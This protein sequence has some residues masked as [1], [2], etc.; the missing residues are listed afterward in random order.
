MHIMMFLS[1]KR[2]WPFAFLLSVS[3][4]GACKKDKTAA[5]VVF[6]VPV[7]QVTQR[8]VPIYREFVGQVL[9][10]SDIEL[11]A[12]VDGWITGLHFTEGGAVKK[13]QLLYSIDPL[14]YRTKVDQARGQVASAEATLANADANLKRIRPLAAINAVSKRDLDAAVADYDVS[15]AQVEAAKANLENQRI[16]LSYT[17]VTSPIDGVIG[18]SKIQVGNYVSSLGAN[19]LLNTVSKINS[20]R[21]RFPVGEQ[22]LLRFQKISR[23]HPDEK[24]LGLEAHLILADGSVFP[25][26]GIVNTVD[27]QVDASTGTLTLQATFPNP[28]QT[29]RPGQFARV[30]LIFENRKNAIVIP[31]RAVTEMQGIFQVMTLTPDNKLQAK[32]VQAGQQIGDEW[33]IDSGLTATDKVALLGNQFI[34]ANTVVKPVAANW[35][36]VDSVSTKK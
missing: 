11:R 21:V 7:L 13:G 29:V 20:L 25:G 6:E 26:K 3:I 36:S 2:A 4:F 1:T 10:E 27:R 30:R 17:Q 34:Q 23:E 5:A 22:D 12:R 9:G 28:D 32:I 8:D 33:I 15:K 31:Q 18:I 16:E 35:K 24:V 14:P 19:G